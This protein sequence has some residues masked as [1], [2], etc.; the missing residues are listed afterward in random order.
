[1]KKKL[2]IWLALIATMLCLATL[3]MV[4][5]STNAE[6]VGAD[7]V[8]FDIYLDYAGDYETGSS[9]LYDH[10]PADYDTFYLHIAE[11]SWVEI[12]IEDCCIMG[13][14]IA[15]ARSGSMYW[16]AT[17]PD[18][19][20]VAGG[21]VPPGVYRFFVGYIDC[22]GGFPAGYYWYFYSSPYAK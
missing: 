17:S 20:Y 22:P 8:V 14:T 13:D 6:E 4:S 11:T 1:M 10:A 12:I 9:N 18:V 21:P 7:G 5:A 3:G 15:L 2:T 19:V 16:S